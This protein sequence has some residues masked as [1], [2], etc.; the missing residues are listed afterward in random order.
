MCI[1][2]YVSNIVQWAAFV[3]A[4]EVHISFA[5]AMVVCDWLS[6]ADPDFTCLPGVV[7]QIRMSS[8]R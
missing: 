8:A 5:Y 6:A 3:V 7:L 2:V 4:I 1:H